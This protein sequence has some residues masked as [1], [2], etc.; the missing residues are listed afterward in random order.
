MTDGEDTWVLYVLLCRYD[1]LTC[2]DRSGPY[3]TGI[4]KDLDARIARHWRGD[5]SKYVYGH[6]P[7]V[8][9]FSVACQD[10][11]EALQLEAKV[12]RLTRPQKEQFMRME[13]KTWA[14]LVRR[15]NPRLVTRAKL[16]EEH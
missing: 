1:G 12:K 3:Y 4:T 8:C 10:K 2:L 16:L 11:S 15:H 13:G 7:F 9:V 5:G 6:K 14:W